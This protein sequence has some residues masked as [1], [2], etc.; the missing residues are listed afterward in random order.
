MK[1]P[2][3]LVSVTSAP[4]SSGSQQRRP[5]LGARGGWLLATALLL[6]IGSAGGCSHTQR[7]GQSLSGGVS[8][9]EMDPLQIEVGKNAPDGM[10]AF[11][12]PSLFQEAGQL[13]DADK[14]ADAATRYDRLVESFADSPYAAPALFNAGL[15]NEALGRYDDAAQRYRRLVRDYSASKHAKESQLRLGACHAELGRWAT[16]S[17]VLAEALRRPDLT[18]SERI[19]VETRKGLAHFE[20]SD[21]AVAEQ[22]MKGAVAYY[23]QHKDEERIE[24]T[25]FL[26]MAHF[27]GAHILHKRFRDLPIRSKPQSLMAQDIDA[28]ARVF[29]AAHL[30]YVETI[31]VKN[32]S[33]A[34]AS[35]YH[36][37]TLYRELYDS[38]V[39]APLPPELAKTEQR[40][41]YDLL[42]RD[43]LRTL[44][45]KAQ[46]VL[47]KNIEMAE[48]V[49]VKNGWVT[50]STE[51]LAELR[52]LLDGLDGPP[53][54]PLAL[55]PPADPAP[56][57]PSKQRQPGT[58][59]K[60]NTPAP[61]AAE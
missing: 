33:W 6:G 23:E 41:I 43:Q 7:T 2:V 45:E 18:L 47:E 22:H 14:F 24:N 30:R 44:L 13:F 3:S 8:T 46:G 50:R 4:T 31:K 20:M 21:L 34:T 52:R 37:G 17:E 12:A 28:K 48:R 32:V 29:L 38:L 49:G 58:R 25:F 40:A 59:A 1:A 57:L 51:Q 5:I 61:A 19:E 55:P 60:A 27:Y 16:S 56:Q 53:S 11:D 26:G 15:S 42:V 36:L 10:E 39:N 54:Q 35:G 9:I